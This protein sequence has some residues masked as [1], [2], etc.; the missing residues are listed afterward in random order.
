M[1]IHKSRKS[2]S[3]INR[4]K[5]NFENTLL[6]QLYEFVRCHSHFQL[7]YEPNVHLECNFNYRIELLGVVYSADVIT[8]WLRQAKWGAIVSLFGFVSIVLRAPF[9][10]L[11]NYLPMNFIFVNQLKN[12]SS[13]WHCSFKIILSMINN[14]NYITLVIGFHNKYLFFSSKDIIIFTYKLLNE[15]TS[16]NITSLLQNWKHLIENNNTNLRIYNYGLLA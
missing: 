13:Q 9:Y 12:T 4:T 7:N 3:Y 11:S 6:K 15:Y 10:S 5:Y 2:E 14:S 8:Y 1:T 16:L